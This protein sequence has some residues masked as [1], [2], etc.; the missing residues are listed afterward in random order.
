MKRNR[1]ALYALILSLSVLTAG[2][3]ADHAVRIPAGT[4]P[5]AG[6]CPAQPRCPAMQQQECPAQNRGEPLDASNRV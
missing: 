5:S 2:V 6:E 1:I 3:A 4:T